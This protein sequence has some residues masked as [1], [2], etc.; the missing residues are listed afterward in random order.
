MNAYEVKLKLKDGDAHD[1]HFKFKDQAEKMVMAVTKYFETKEFEEY[2]FILNE[3]TI[4][5]TEEEFADDVLDALNIVL[6]KDKN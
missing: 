4:Y 3:V 2:K 6:S 1:F 5:E